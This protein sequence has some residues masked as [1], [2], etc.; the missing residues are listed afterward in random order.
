MSTVTQRGESVIDLRVERT[1]PA[2][3]PVPNWLFREVHRPGAF[4]FP[5]RLFIA[6]GWLRS[7]AEHL[8]DAR[9]MGGAAVGDFVES[10]TSAGAIVFPGYEWLV[11]SVIGPAGGLVGWLV[12]LLQLGIGLAILT[13]SFA[14]LAFLVGIV[15]NINFMLA[16]E[17]NPSAFYILI[18]SVL[19]VTG[20]GAVFGFDGHRS[21]HL[22]RSILLVARPDTRGMSAEDRWAISSLAVLAATVAWLGFTHVHDFSPTGVGDPGLVLG[23]VMALATLLLVILRLRMVD[24]RKLARRR[25]T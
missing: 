3:G 16:G 22:G 4:L 15:L 17:V 18:Q 9:W 12:M 21:S 19:F 1:A 11:S 24:V 5:L 14:N 7:F 23:T 6:I 8:G 25:I 2:P 10:Q 20:A 13:G